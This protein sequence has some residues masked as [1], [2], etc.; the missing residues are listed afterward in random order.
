[1]PKSI[2]IKRVG[3]PEVLE[4][5]ETKVNSPGPEE[6]KVTNYAIGLNYIDTYH[7]SGLYPLTMPTGIGL[8]AAGKIDEVGSNVKEL[9]K[10]D[11][12][13]YA[14]MP[15]GAYSQQRIIPAKIAVKVP[16]GISHKLAATLMT[17]GLTTNYL[18]TKTYLLKAGETVLFHAAAGGVGQI[19]AQWAN[20]I[21]AK[22]IGT[23]GTDEKIQA[24]KENGYAHVINYSKNDFSKEVMRITNNKGVPAVFDG[25]GKKT[26]QGSLACLKPLGM[27]I[28]FGNASGPLDPLNVPKDIQSKSLFF[29]RP[30]IGHYFGNRK[31]LQ[32][33]AD[34]IFE[35]VKFG[36]IKIKISKEYKLEDA[37]E[38]HKD[39]EARKLI[40]PAILIP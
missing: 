22:V 21:G 26:F 31:E 1:M 30:T 17:K 9:N 28:S 24:A 3:G 11:N 5:Q 40:G 7:R 6:I 32:A 36:K 13:A 4:I 2:I 8:E 16:D 37:K 20:S 39:L 19:F 33:G 18:L 14:S 38:A 10:G 34:E 35:K 25:V 29:T 27:M 23:V 12:V 15:I